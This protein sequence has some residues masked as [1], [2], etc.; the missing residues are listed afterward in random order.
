[1]SPTFGVDIV[2]AKEGILLFLG[3]ETLS[4]NFLRIYVTYENEKHSEITQESTVQGK[5]ISRGIKS[6]HPLLNQ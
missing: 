5:M 4:C 2:T 6:S 1:V 3:M